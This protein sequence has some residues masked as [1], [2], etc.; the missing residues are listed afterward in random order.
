M[1]VAF[2]RVALSFILAFF[3]VSA[4]ADSTLLR[5]EEPWVRA[6]VAS[7]QATGVF[8]R[9]TAREALTLVGARSPVAERPELHVSEIVEGVMKMRPIQSLPMVAGELVL[10]QPGSVHIM[11]MGLKQTLTVGQKVPLVLIF[12][13][14]RGKRH[15]LK[16]KAEVRALAADHPVQ[17][18]EQESAQEYVPAH[19][20]HHKHP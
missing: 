3:A 12:E 5:V 4:R 20:N 18:T 6:S 8:M 11:L 14:A 10:L 13:D 2:R 1:R 16:I 7:Q 9:L 19:M 17:G 15:E